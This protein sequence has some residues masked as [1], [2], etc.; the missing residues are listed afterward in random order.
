MPQ[1]GADLTLMLVQDDSRLQPGHYE[2]AL[3]TMAWKMVIY[4]ELVWPHDACAREA[5]PLPVTVVSKERRALK[6]GP[7]TGPPYGNQVH[8]YIVYRA[9]TARTGFYARDVVHLAL[10]PRVYDPRIRAPNRA[11]LHMPGR[12]NLQ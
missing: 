5:M 2:K 1:A 8:T 11:P 4:R 7:K 9:N 10:F 12:T 6:Q 3:P